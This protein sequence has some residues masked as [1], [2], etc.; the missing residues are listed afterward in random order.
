MLNRNTL[1]YENSIRL[2]ELLIIIKDKNNYSLAGM[3][4]EI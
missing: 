1:L 4:C 2:K 3:Q